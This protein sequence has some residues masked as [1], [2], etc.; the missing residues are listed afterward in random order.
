[1]AS[2][3]SGAGQDTGV[4]AVEAA[5]PARITFVI[6][7]LAAGGAERVATLMVN[8]WAEQGRR[9]TLITL[10]GDAEDFYGL[11]SRIKRIAL[12]ASEKSP[13]IFHAI[14]HNIR[15]LFK[16][17][18]PI[19]ASCADAVI[20]FTEKT[21]VLTL[22]ATRGLGIPVVVSERSDPRQ[23]RI[24]P[25]WGGLRKLTYRWADALAVQTRSVSE[26][27]AQSVVARNIRVIPNPV[28]PVGDLAERPGE[29]QQPFLVAMGRL[30]REKGFDMLLHAAAA[31]LPRHPEWTMV[32][33]GE[34]PERTALERLAVDLG[35]RGRV[36]FPGRHA[37]PFE[38]LKK[39]EMFV[40]PSRFEGFP[41]AL[42]EAM[43][44]GLAVVSFDCPSGPGEIVRDG[45]D[46]VLVPPENVHALAIA[47]DNMMSDPA[48]RRKMGA[49]AAEIAARLAPEKVMAL[50]DR[51][52]IDVH[53]KMQDE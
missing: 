23:Y 32:V 47:I 51:L 24:G 36:R 25:V 20:A 16:L 30:S 49:R 2:V 28:A 3:D 50:W 1:M 11:D 9:V 8:H 42:C 4:R 14:G 48:K 6:S 52:L 53:R 41:N 34:G 44:C 7:S 43:A 22:L 19:R 45:V 31:V 21:N 40:L 29:P 35:L 37:N 18:A 10:A 27:A 12:H 5:G 33:L 15:R 39:A 38:V 13:T 46:G 26:W 17:R